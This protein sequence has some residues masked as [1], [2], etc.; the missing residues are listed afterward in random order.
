[1]HILELWWIYG[2]VHPFQFFATEGPVVDAAVAAEVQYKILGPGIQPASQTPVLGRDREE[3]R[4]A[5]M[6]GEWLVY[7]GIVV[8]QL[9]KK[10]GMDKYRMVPP[11]YKLVYKPH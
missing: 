6:V 11:S 4:K 5:L 8:L 1:M 3:R 7:V 10:K 9:A 2:F